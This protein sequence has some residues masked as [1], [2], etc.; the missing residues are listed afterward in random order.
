MLSSSRNC[1]SIWHLPR[2]LVL[3]LAG[4]TLAVILAGCNREV[5]QEAPPVRPVRTVIMEKGGLG[6][7]IVLT[8]QIRAEKEVALALHRGPHC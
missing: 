1:C 5:A 2:P 3:V 8:G 4:M 7:T 6:K